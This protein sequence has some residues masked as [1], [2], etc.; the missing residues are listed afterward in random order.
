MIECWGAKIQLQDPKEVR[1]YSGGSCV[2]RAHRV[3]KGNYKVFELDGMQYERQ[4]FNKNLPTLIVPA[5]SQSLRMMAWRSDIGEEYLRQILQEVGFSYDKSGNKVSRSN[6]D[7]SFCNKV[8]LKTT[9]S[10][11]QKFRYKLESIMRIDTLSGVR[12]LYDYN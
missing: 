11:I 3:A 1:L 8:L 2:G 9:E 7:K 6:H 10:G 12:T 4:W 5:T